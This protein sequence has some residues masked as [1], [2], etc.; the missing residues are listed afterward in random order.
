MHSVQPP[1]RKPHQQP[2]TNQGSNPKSSPLPWL[3]WWL[4][5]YH[6]K[7]AF[8]RMDKPNLKTV[9][10]FY[11]TLTKDKKGHTQK[12]PKHIPAIVG[13]QCSQPCFGQRAA[14]PNLFGQPLR[15]VTEVH[16][17]HWPD[18][19]LW[20]SIA[21]PATL[22]FGDPGTFSGHGERWWTMGSFSD[23]GYTIPYYPLKLWNAEMENDP[24]IRNC[25]IKNIR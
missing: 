6:H 14:A 5:L 3:W 17:R 9:H 8:R 2:A 21:T 16:P 24:F 20:S 13:L 10:W 1:T 15:C 18:S 25:S 23:L 19:L 22:D 4:R 12:Y 7:I 11:F